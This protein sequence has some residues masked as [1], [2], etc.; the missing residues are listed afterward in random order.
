MSNAFLIATSVRSTFR[1][2]VMHRW[3]NFILRVV[4]DCLGALVVNTALND[5][6]AIHLLQSFN[7]FRLANASTCV[8]VVI[9]CGVLLFTKE[10]DEA[11]PVLPQII[12]QRTTVYQTDSSRSIQTLRKQPDTLT[13]KDTLNR[14]SYRQEIESRRCSC[15]KLITK[16]DRRF[17]L[18]LTLQQVVAAKQNGQLNHSLC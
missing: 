8:L 13:L 14:P 12:D 6:K 9:F 11:N 1:F 15:V 7:A 17:L 16:K 5:K 4:R 2:F 10:T 18:Y 3:T